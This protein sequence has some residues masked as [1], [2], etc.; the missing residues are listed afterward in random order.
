MI[1]V[2]EVVESWWVSEDVI[3]F[4]L[5]LTTAYVSIVVD[6]WWRAAKGVMDISNLVNRRPR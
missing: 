2:I 1:T 3:D 5:F 4:S 6:S